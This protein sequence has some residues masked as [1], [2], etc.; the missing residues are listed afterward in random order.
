MEDSIEMFFS[1][2]KRH[3]R[4]TPAMNN[5]VYGIHLQHLKELRTEHKARRGQRFSTPVS[6][7]RAK[8]IAH[9]C[10]K[11]AVI[12]VS[13]CEPGRKRADIF[14]EF[15]EWFESKGKRLLSM[16]GGDD[17]EHDVGFEHFGAHGPDF[18]EEGDSDNTEGDVQFDPALRL[19]D[20]ATL[21]EKLE[22]ATAKVEG[23][24]T[25]TEAEEKD[26]A[27]D[28]ARP[29]AG[30]EAEEPLTL[31][32]HK[33]VKSI[34]EQVPEAAAVGSKEKADAH[35]GPIQTLQDIIV[36]YKKAGHP[37]PDGKGFE[38]KDA[39]QRF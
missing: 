32:Q 6:L 4:G 25:L 22:A 18:F 17:P 16:S 39:I 26:I 20:R 12:L 13:F 23:E 19:A 34:A 38:N 36:A 35:R 31:E 3:T 28:C 14:T 2:I 5:L 30:P 33:E 11:Y 37:L 1:D 8:E 10:L 21:V 29:A 7:A 15:K 9:A 24:V 27:N